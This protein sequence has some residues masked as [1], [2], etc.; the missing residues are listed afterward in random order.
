MS[1]IKDLINQLCPDS[2]EYKRLGDVAEFNRGKALSRSEMND[3]QYPVVAGGI[4]PVSWCDKFN[5]TGESVSVSASGANAGYINYWNEPIF[6]TDAFT[7]DVD[8]TDVLPKYLYYVLSNKQDYIHSLK[9]GGGVPHVYGR[10]IAN[11]EIPVPPIEVQQEIV[12]ILDKFTAL[13]TAL[14]TEL[15]LRKQQYEYYRDQL[16]SFD[17]LKSLPGGASVL[18][19]GDIGQLY[20]GLSGKSKGDFSEY[21]NAKYVSYSGIFNNLAVNSDCLESVTIGV[22]EK[23]RRVI[24][25]DVLFTGSSETPD[26]VAYS[27]VVD[28]NLGDDIYLNSFSVGYRFNNL[29]DIDPG[30]VKYVFRSRTLRRQLRKTAMG[31][32]RFNVSKNRLKKVK[33]CI[34]PLSEQRRI[35]NILDKFSAITTS[36]TDGLP[37]EIALRQKQYEYYRDKLLT[38]KKK[39][40]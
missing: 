5:R 17:Y 36:L 14:Q 10:M 24:Y 22:N 18:T 9:K 38:F 21:G 34:P 30:F 25:G 33:I 4:K 23:Q 20:G 13:Q 6:V 8:Q 7:I 27:S 16:L 26:E 19:L 1:K 29:N 31:V 32:T 39:V 2:V 35:K 40:Q 3:G 37:A 28:S 11:L 15:D 12:D